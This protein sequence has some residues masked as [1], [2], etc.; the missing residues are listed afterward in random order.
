MTT[1]TMSSGGRKVRTQADGPYHVEHESFALPDAEKLYSP[2]TSTEAPAGAGH[3]PDETTRDYA[4]RM[5]YAA[6]RMAQATDVRTRNRW[7]RHYLAFRDKIVM[8]NRK[9]IFRAVRRW[10]P[11]PTLAD[12]MVGDCQIVLIQAVAA[13][14]P[15]MGIRFSTYAFTCLMRALSRISQK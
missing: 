4:K 9:L 2:L 6:H 8:G 13:Y 12:D 10:Q 1:A 3:L 5:H 7:Q 11:T 15:W 14:N